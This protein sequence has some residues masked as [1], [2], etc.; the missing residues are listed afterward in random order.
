MTTSSSLRMTQS[1]DQL[2]LYDN[3]YPAQFFMRHY[4]RP[5]LS[6][7]AAAAFVTLA[8]P[9]FA[10]DAGASSSS[11]APSPSVPKCAAPAPLPAEF[12]GFDAPLKQAASLTPDV[13]PSLGL[14]NAYRLD[15]SP[16]LGVAYITA[17]KKPP[18][19]GRYA[20]LVSFTIDKDGLYSIATSDSVWLDVYAGTE[21]IRASTSGRIECSAIHKVVHFALKPGIYRL[22]VSN[23]SV[24]AVTVM[25]APKP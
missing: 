6:A 10:Q 18:E 15:L 23:S 11:S 7:L 2:R 14:G 22:Q 8:L 16:A 3:H 12:K 21:F 17:P 13:A 24:P 9:A 5:V 1:Y 19:D 4:M 20:G 25:I